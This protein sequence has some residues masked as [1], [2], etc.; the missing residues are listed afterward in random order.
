M[1]VGEGRRES[2]Q[3]CTCQRASHQ[4]SGTQ[5]VAS[6]AGEVTGCALFFSAELAQLG[7]HLLK[8]NVALGLG[9]DKRRADEEADRGARHTGI[10]GGPT[11][12]LLW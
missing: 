6:S 12:M 11:R 7:K 9:V 10:T 3:L 1:P 8:Q 2:S 5:E 4:D